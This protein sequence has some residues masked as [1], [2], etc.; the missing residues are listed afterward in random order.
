MFARHRPI[1]ILALLLVGPVAG[2]VAAAGDGPAGKEICRLAAD[3]AER[4][5]R[6]PRQLLGA[7]ARAESGRYDARTRASFAWPWT[8]QAAGRSRYLPDKAS[9]IAAVRR[10]RARGVRNIDVGCMQISLLHHGDAFRTLEQA[11]DPAGNADYAGRFLTALKQELRSWSRAIATYH[12]RT[13][14]LNKPYARKVMALWR[15][16]RHLAYLARA[17][18]NRRA[19]L[20]RR[21]RAPG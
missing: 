3:R 17:E 13:P 6:I 2:P 21:A 4:A 8:V 1:L 9:A 15:D 18:A 16:E 20:A 19:V 12:S 5:W 7:I 10:L 14:A 11:F